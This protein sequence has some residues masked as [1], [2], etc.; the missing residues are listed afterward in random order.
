MLLGN[1][2]NNL[3]Y[4]MLALIVSLII[5]ST[6]MSIE[7][8]VKSQGTV[9]TSE[10]RKIVTHYEGGVIE[11]ILVEEGQQVAKGE[12][13]M[14]IDNLSIEEKSQ[15]NETNVRSLSAKLKRLKAEI[16]GKPSFDLSADIPFAAYEENTFKARYNE[17]QT[18]ISIIEDRISQKQIDLDD[19]ASQKVNLQQQRDIFQQQ[20]DLLSD[21]VKQEATSLNMLLEKE[22]ELVGANRQLNEVNYAIERYKVELKEL[23][24]EIEFE[25]D[26]YT[27]TAQE[28]YDDVLERFRDTETQLMV[29]RERKSRSLLTSPHAGT[30]YKIHSNTIGE[31]VKS[32]QVLIE[33][34]PETRKLIVKAKIVSEDRDKIWNGMSARVSPVFRDFK[35][36]PI[37]AE[38]V[39]VSADSSYDEVDRKRYFDVLLESESFVKD[40]HKFIV[41]GM[42][43]DVSV[44]T[45]EHRLLEYLLRPVLRGKD[46]MFSE[47]I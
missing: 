12:S 32:G 33:I 31:T 39:Q 35:S 37:D 24:K 11:S 47:P 1:A 14:S 13:L 27:S 18:R 34:V 10:Q 42:M 15:Q 25:K 8:A 19:F 46:A 9:V 44:I 16:A 30:I 2:S 5:W 26:R 45:G 43:V 6:A 7:S 23:K 4:L 17:L 21:L 28:E 36:Q 29:T 20:Y 41:S 38:V 3:I 40:K 22:S